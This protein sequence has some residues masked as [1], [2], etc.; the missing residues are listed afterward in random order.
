MTCWILVWTGLCTIDILF[1]LQ[2]F[3]SEHAIL[4]RLA[5]G[6]V[7]QFIVLMPTVSCVLLRIVVN[8]WFFL[9][10]YDLSLMLSCFSLLRIN[11]SVFS[12]EVTTL[13]WHQWNISLIVN[14]SK[15]SSLVFGPWACSLMAHGLSGLTTINVLQCL[16]FRH[17]LPSWTLICKACSH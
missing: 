17:Y 8:N 10:M 4:R 5:L 6:T 15:K 14:V 11:I 1:V 13:Q 12:T 2:F 16:S 7:N 3:T 9:A